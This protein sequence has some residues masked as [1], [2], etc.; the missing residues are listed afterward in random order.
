MK[1]LITGNEGMIGSVVEK[2][3]RADGCEV[4]GFDITSGHNI[5]N[6]NE[7]RS[8][9]QGC[10]AIVHLAALLGNSEDTPNEIMAVNVLGTWHILSAAAEVKLKRVVFF[11]SVDV[12]GIFKG[13][14]KP[15]YLPLDD[16]H[17]C[18]PT[19]TYAVSKRLGEEMCRYFTNSTGISTI[20][21]RPP[22]VFDEETYDFI[23]S[24][25]QANP[26]FEW[27]PFWEYGAFLDVRDAAEAAQ[28]ALH[29]PNPGHV[30]LL[31]CADDISSAYRTS[32][33]MAQSLLPEIDW[34]GGD[35][36][37]HEPYKALINTQL[38][39]EVLQWIPRYKWR[40]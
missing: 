27:N 15:D 7:I 33:E 35:E 18:Y 10:D 14:R 23:I 39:K 32:Q 34:R 21:L 19:T 3:L 36:Y 4:I 17:P 37:E 22:G 24:N 6:P 40:P 30:T 13:E 11:S 20:C 29:C 28:Y 5:L 25:R 31:L 9:V 2:V 8:A 1:V 38:A 16:N 12:L 26:D